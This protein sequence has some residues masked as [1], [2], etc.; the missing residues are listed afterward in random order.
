MEDE[1]GF[2]REK[3]I[4]LNKG[5]PMFKRFSF[6]DGNNKRLKAKHCLLKDRV[7]P[8]RAAVQLGQFQVSEF[9]FFGCEHDAL[10]H[11]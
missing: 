7:L 9:H 10:Y 6:F 2:L 11:G 1:L 3:E 8:E 4:G 5:K